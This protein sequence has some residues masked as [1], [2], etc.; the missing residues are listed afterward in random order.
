M[1]GK[2]AQFESRPINHSL[3]ASSFSLPVLPPALGVPRVSTRQGCPEVTGVHYLD[4]HQAPRLLISG[5]PRPG[6][7]QT[8]AAEPPRRAAQGGGCLGD[9]APGQRRA[10]PLTW[11]SRGWGSPSLAEATQEGFQEEAALHWALKHV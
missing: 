2:S 4:S 6:E 1:E 10:L 8:A 7:G 9:R 11:R 3:V 5:L